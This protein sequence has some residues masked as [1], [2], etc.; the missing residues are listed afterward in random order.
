[1]S[2]QRI[3]KTYSL[4]LAEHS[5]AVEALG[6]REAAGEPSRISGRC[7]HHSWGAHSSGRAQ[8]R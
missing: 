4:R 1:M 8:E 3:R 7:L 2:H 5:E 6:L